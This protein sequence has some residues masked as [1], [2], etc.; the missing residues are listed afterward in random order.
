MSGDLPRDRLQRIVDAVETIE[1]SIGVLAEKRRQTD[2]ETYKTDPDTRDIVERRFVKTTEAALDI[3]T[4]LVVHER[5]DPPESNPAT[6]RSLGDLGILSEELA[7]EMAATARF[8]N[9]LAHT[10]GDA[11]DDDVVYDAL[12]DLERYRS[13]LLA[14]REHLDSIGALE[15]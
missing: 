7:D 8:R 14:V 10:Y 4:V 2:R 6:M 3:G 9:V 5:G 13:F 15:D 1:D 12:D 11:I